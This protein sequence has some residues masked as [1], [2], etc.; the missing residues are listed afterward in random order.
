MQTFK[1]HMYITYIETICQVLLSIFANFGFPKTIALRRL[2]DLKLMDKIVEVRNIRDS[3]SIVQ[4]L[5]RE[6]FCLGKIRMDQIRISNIIS[7][8]SMY[9]KKHMS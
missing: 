1:V 9:T 8:Q 7:D 2:C 5:A 3:F 4:S 6:F